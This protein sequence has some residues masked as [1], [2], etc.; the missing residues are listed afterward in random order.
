MA[1]ADNWYTTEMQKAFAGQKADTSI[2]QVD[3]YTVG[4][5]AG[6]DN[7]YPVLRGS[8]VGTVIEPAND[9]D[10][11]KIIGIALHR[12]KEPTA[13][14]VRYYEQYDQ[15]SVMTL[16]DVYMEAGAN[17]V[18]GNVGSFLGTAGRYKIV[19]AGT[20][21]AIAVTG[22]EILESGSTG[23]IVKVRVRK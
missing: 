12:H 5:S 2:D 18:A 16:G 11:A 20:A 7:G 13:E 9:T 22:F 14:G 23:D 21:S 3:S 8:T 6:I 10:A 1:I 4:S 15:V 17:V 19:P